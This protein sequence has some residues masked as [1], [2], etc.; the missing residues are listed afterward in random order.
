MRWFSL[1]KAYVV[2]A[3]KR[4]VE[5]KVAFWTFIIVQLLGLASW[6]I[7]WKVLLDRV[8]TFGS[9]DLPMMVLLM[10]FLNF[11]MGVWFF[12]INI[13]SLPEKILDGSFSEYLTRPLHPLLHYLG[14]N[15]NLTNIFRI[16]IGLGLVFFALFYFDIQASPINLALAFLISFLAVPATLLPFITLCLSA[17]WIGKA[18]FLR[19]LAGELFVYENYPLTEF[20]TAFRRIFTYIYP[21]AFSGAIPAL[22]AI[23]L[24]FFRGIEVLF[25]LSLIVAIQ[26]TIFNIVWRKGLRRYES[27]GG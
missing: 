13:W 23:E 26:L 2:N 24:S 16:I 9:F 14:R 8:G 5:Y 11:H 4:H 6:L 22:I 15:L 21:L 18:D 20:P 27:H 25:V 10:G 12:V 3:L 1:T 19:D 7:F 17:F